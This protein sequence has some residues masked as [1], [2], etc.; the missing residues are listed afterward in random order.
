MIIVAYEAL[1]RTQV[2]AFPDP[3]ARVYNKGGFIEVKVGSETIAS[4]NPTKFICA[5]KV[6]PEAVARAAAQ[7]PIIPPETP[8]DNT[9][10]AVHPASGPEGQ[11]DSPDRGSAG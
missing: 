6:D 8:N 1:D 3:E 4:Y 2:D 10:E 7:A 5:R 9:P 11:Q